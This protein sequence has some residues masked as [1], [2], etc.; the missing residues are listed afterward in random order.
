MVVI[1]AISLTACSSSGAATSNPSVPSLAG[2]AS[3]GQSAGPHPSGA[4]QQSGKTDGPPSGHDYSAARVTALH[5]AAA[6]IRAHGIPGYTDPVLTP[7]GA[8]YSDRRPFEDASDATRAAVTHACGTLMAQA[9]LNPDYEPPAPPQLVQA[10][11]ASARCMRAHGMPNLRDPNPQ[12][13][14][15]PGHGFGLSADE[16]PA[17]G[18]ANPVFQHAIQACQQVNS[19]EIRASTLGSL[20]NDG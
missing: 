10:G 8:T 15:T 20:S 3:S 9:S 16:V 6:C 12:A 13:P 11:V 5:N 7:S 2:N 19:A 17:G 14:Y 1:T 18:K 4:G